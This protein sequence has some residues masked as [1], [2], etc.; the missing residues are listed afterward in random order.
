M[1]KAV[2]IFSM[3][4]SRKHSG[5][6]NKCTLARLITGFEYFIAGLI[7]VTVTE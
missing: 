7:D 3:H 2:M 4:D 1:L 5:N 6:K